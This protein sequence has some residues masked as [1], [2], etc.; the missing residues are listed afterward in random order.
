MILFGVVGYLLK[1][2]GYECTPL[3]FA[4]VLSP[5]LEQALR[6]SLLISQGSFM[7]FINRPISGAILGVAILLLLS[8]LFPFIKKRRQKYVAREKVHDEEENKI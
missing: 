3:M 2:F 7:I 1:K 6:Q 8:N 4:L 5:I